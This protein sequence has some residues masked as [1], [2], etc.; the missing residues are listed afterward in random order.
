MYGPPPTMLHHLEAHRGGTSSEAHL[1]PKAAGLLFSCVCRRATNKERP[2][3]AHSALSI[4]NL[5]N[6]FSLS[7]EN[8]ARVSHRLQEE[9]F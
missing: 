5:S 4:G 9:M 2:S 6:S 3:L 8:S 1:L 7:T